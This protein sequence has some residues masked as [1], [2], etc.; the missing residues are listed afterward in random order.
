MKPDLSPS[1][2]H[3]D[4]RIAR[5]AAE[6]GLGTALN[7][8]PTRYAIGHPAAIRAVEGALSLLVDLL[9]S[10]GM[11]A[12]QTLVATKYQ[13]SLYPGISLADRESAISFCIARY[14]VRTP[15][16]VAREPT[17]RSGRPPQ[18]E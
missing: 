13:L 10:E 17:T 14:F 6:K 2:G 1:D 7:A 11:D 9:R 5:A 4:R 12:A 15:E 16:E 8:V 18:G 3:D